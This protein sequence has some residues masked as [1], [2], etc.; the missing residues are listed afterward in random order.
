MKKTGNLKLVS[1][2]VVM[3]LLCGMLC[4]PTMAKE[5][6]HLLNPEFAIEE[7]NGKKTIPGWSLYGNATIDEVLTPD[8]DGYSENPYVDG[9]MFH[10]K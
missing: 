5:G 2:A 8:A 9:N 6:N 1:L 4:L 10:S 3:F 7:N